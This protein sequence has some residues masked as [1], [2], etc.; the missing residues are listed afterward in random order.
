MFD[1]EIPNGFDSVSKVYLVEYDNGEPYE[2]NFHYIKGVFKTQEAAEKYLDSKY[3]RKH[4]KYWHVNS[5]V[6]DIVW[7]Y[8][9]FIC[10]MNNIDCEDCPKCKDYENGWD[11]CEEYDSRLDSEYDNSYYI[12]LKY[13]LL[14]ENKG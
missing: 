13:D 14:D 12:I 11:C 2:E 8:P 7:G 6:D 10:S 9:K 4:T 1:R 3:E 5:A